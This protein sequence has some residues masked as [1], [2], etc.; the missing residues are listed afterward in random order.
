M[1]GPRAAVGR[2]PYPHRTQAEIMAAEGR[3]AESRFAEKLRRIARELE[4]ERV[5]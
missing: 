4:R 2:F 3:V 1:S 5:V